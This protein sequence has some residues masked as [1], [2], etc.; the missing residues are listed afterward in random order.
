M[1][2]EF[3]FIFIKI[4]TL[5]Y[6]FYLYCAGEQN[7]QEKTHQPVEKTYQPVRHFSFP[8]F[9]LTFI[10]SRLQTFIKHYYVVASGSDAH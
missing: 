3:N 7:K 1:K 5:K 6:V 10:S 2:L 9:P 4:Y 8:I